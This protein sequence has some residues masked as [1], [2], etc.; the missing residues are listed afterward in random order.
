MYYNHPMKLG[1]FKYKDQFYQSGTKVL[2][3]GQCY[4]GEEEV[5]LSNV[6]VE[7]VRVEGQWW[8]FRYNDQLYQCEENDYTSY[9]VKS[10]LDQCIVQIVVDPVDEPDKPKTKEVIWTKGMVAATIW[11][12]FIMLVGT[13]FYDRVL[14]WI[15]ATLVWLAYIRKNRIIIEK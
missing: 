9:G 2:F 8:V 15:G 3:N 4:L 6:V 12:I 10:R 7:F 5:T 14:I 1:F 13:I 11:Y